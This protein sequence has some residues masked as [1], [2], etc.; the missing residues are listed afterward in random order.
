[1]TIPTHRIGLRIPNSKG[2]PE[3]YREWFLA[4]LVEKGDCWIWPHGRTWTSPNGHPSPQGWGRVFFNGSYNWPAHKVA[5][6]LEHGK[7]SC[8]KA[9]RDVLLHNCG[10][11]RCCRLE[12][13][14]LDPDWLEAEAQKK[15]FAALP[16]RPKNPDEGAFT[17]WFW[18][19][20]RTVG[21]CWLWGKD[22]K[23]FQTT[24]QGKPRRV[25]V[26]AWILGK[27][28]EPKKGYRV[29]RTCGQERC[30]RPD[31]LVEEP[32]GKTLKLLDAVR[33]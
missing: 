19:Q 18:R 6:M 21:D 16:T 17:E 29:Q 22:T 25:N 33:G 20:T 30:V 11:P 13:L 24:F 14:F 12:H 27:N 15:A 31:H 26:I 7:G 2:D 10:E 23:V 5:W 8:G 28:R 4:Q 32:I 9:E 3:A 1:M